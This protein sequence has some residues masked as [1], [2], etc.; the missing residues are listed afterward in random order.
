M[1]GQHGVGGIFGH[2]GRGDVHEQHAVVVNQEGTVELR[3]ERARPLALDA[4][5]HAVGRHEVLDGGTLLEK[6]GVRGDVELH[7]AA[8]A[9]ELLA[10]DGL[11]FAG[12]AD[13]HRALGH[14]QR[15][16]ADVAA[17]GAGHLEH[18]L[19]VGRTVLVGRGADRREDHLY[20]VEARA[21]V[22]G[23]VQP[24]C[25]DIACDELVEPRL[26]NRNDALQQAVDFFTVGVHAGDVESHLG[27][28]CARDQSHVSGSYDCD[29]HWVAVSARKR[30]IRFTARRKE[31]G[32]RFC[33]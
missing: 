9:A 4:H 23:E 1:R 10:D 19:E 26:V 17:E 5:H 25:A 6:F 31:C 28:A 2:L 20:L 13:G 3:H 27:E 16:F 15:V 21:E 24:A 12:R 32:G 7:V 8:A 22:G 29:F 33:P 14:Q 18:V 11:D 30:G